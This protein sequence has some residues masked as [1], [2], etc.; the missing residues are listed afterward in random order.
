MCRSGFTDGD[1]DRRQGLRAETLRWHQRRAHPRESLD[2]WGVVVVEL[3]TQPTSERNEKLRVVDLLGMEMK[4]L[5]I[6]LGITPLL[7]VSISMKLG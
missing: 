7:F 3:T 5:D 2:R 1:G 4:Y 6:Q